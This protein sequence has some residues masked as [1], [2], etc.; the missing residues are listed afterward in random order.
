MEWTITPGIGL[1]PVRIG[2]ARPRVI[3]TLGEPLT[4]SGP[5]AL[6]GGPQDFFRDG[7]VQIHYDRRHEVTACTV[8]RGG[9]LLK[10]ENACVWFLGRHRMAKL[11]ERHAGILPPDPSLAHWTFPVERMG[12]QWGSKRLEA[13][14]VFH[15]SA[16]G[17]LAR[18]SHRALARA[19]DRCA[20]SR[21]WPRL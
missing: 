14:S 8:W 12:F 21:G 9:P 16:L 6:G 17:K 5:Q 15:A 19:Q 11:L 7:S 13:V 2:D 3:E 10:L 4:L 18:L 1:G 20:D